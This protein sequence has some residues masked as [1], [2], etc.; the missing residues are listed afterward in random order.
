AEA[1]AVSARGITPEDLAGRTDLRDRLVFTIDPADAKDHDDALSVASLEDGLFEVGIHIADVSFYVR[2]GS[3]LDLEALDRG[4]SVYLVD[5]VIPMLPHELS[6]DLCSLRPDV[7]RL[8][9]SL[10]LR[11]DE[12]GHV[13]SEEL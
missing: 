3:A 11:L 7:D 5:R 2:E 4:T 13:R 8:A 6:S 1:E 10:L 12:D 9:M